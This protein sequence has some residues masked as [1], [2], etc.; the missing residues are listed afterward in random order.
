MNNSN[1]SLVTPE[2]IM[3]IYVVNQAETEQQSP[4]LFN[5]YARSH[6]QSTLQ[7]MGCKLNDADAITSTNFIHDDFF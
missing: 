4:L 3:F 7:L 2:D 5:S 1:A 6:V